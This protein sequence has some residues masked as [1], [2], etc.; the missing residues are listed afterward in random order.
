MGQL[1][2]MTI[3][4][5]KAAKSGIQYGVCGEQGG[6]PTSVAFFHKVRLSLDTMVWCDGM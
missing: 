4:R 6:E 3:D 5:S 2:K 1:I